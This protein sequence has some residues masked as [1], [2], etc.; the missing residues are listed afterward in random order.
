MME[1]HKKGTSQNSLIENHINRAKIQADYDRDD[2]SGRKDSLTQAALNQK[3]R[4]NSTFEAQHPDVSDSKVSRSTKNQSAYERM[5]QQHFPTTEPSP[6]EAERAAN[7]PYQM[8]PMNMLNSHT[9]E[10]KRRN[11]APASGSENNYTRKTT[12]DRFEDIP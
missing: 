3:A 2:I 4:A 1:N 8:N 10:L 5:K 11:A 12:E 9:S 6:G 7:N